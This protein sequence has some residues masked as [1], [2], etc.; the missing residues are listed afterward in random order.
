MFPSK[1]LEFFSGLCFA[2]KIIIRKVPWDQ[3]FIL[4]AVCAAEA[5]ETFWLGRAE[6]QH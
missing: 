4:N 6:K 5:F 3:K 1:D 2:H